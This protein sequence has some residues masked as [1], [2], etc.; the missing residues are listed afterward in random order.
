[1]PGVRR[2]ILQV[3]G[4]RAVSKKNHPRLGRRRGFSL[5]ELMLVLLLIGVLVA[6]ALP[7]YKGYKERTRVAQAINDITAISMAAT[8]YWIDNRAY[9]ASLADIGLAGKLDP[10]GYPYVYYNID[11]GGK[12]GARKDHALNPLN[13]DF[14]VY[15]VGADGVSKPQITQKDSLDDVIRASNG[16][17]LGLASTF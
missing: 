3:G 7:F 1:M 5:I 9:P 8:N 4:E 16:A 2:P 12:G 6:V 17:F 14:D 15:S 11:A 10:W 13:T